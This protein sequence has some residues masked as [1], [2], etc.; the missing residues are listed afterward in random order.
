MQGYDQARHF[1]AFRRAQPPHTD[2][3]KQSTSPPT[4]GRSLRNDG[5]D[6][7]RRPFLLPSEGLQPCVAPYFA[8]LGR[9]DMRGVATF[10]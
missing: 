1:V 7:R 5:D 8:T 3:A 6:D 9:G 4:T 10:H 2:S